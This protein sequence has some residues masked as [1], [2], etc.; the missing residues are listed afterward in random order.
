MRHPL[1][2]TVAS[3]G[4]LIALAIPALG[5]HTA[6]S[7]LEQLPHTPIMKTFERRCRRRSPARPTPAWS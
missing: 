2:S 1:I 6:Q 5:M 3:A 7:G 4:V